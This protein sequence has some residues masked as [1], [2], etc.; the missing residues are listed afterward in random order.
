VQYVY[1]LRTDKLEGDSSDVDWKQ[2]CSSW[3][4][5]MGRM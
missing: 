3:D 1:V 2:S 5:L 4:G